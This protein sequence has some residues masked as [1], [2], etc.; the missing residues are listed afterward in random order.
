MIKIGVSSCFM[1][2]DPNRAIFGPKTLL[3]MGYDM[4]HYIAQN[5]VMPILI[6]DLMDDTLF[7]NYLDQMDGFLFQGGTDIDPIFYG[8][9]PINEEC[10]GDHRRDAYE[11]KILDYAIERKKPILLICRGMQLLNVYCNGTLYQDIPQLI[12]KAVKHRDN[13]LYDELTHDIEFS[14]NSVLEKIHK[15]QTIKIVNSVHHQA[16]K[17]LGQNLI[18]EAVSPDDQIIEAIRYLGPASADKGLKTLY[19][20]GLVM[21][22]QWHPEFFHSMKTKTIEAAPM[23]SHFVE[24]C[25]RIKINS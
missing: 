20:Q 1:Y 17:K 14:E 11:L 12:P 4:V 24:F 7:Y 6:P 19:D 22:I 16:V 5:G 21:G 15:G 3:Y 9:D 13:D 25:K 10:I 23:V 18:V 8:E 2:P